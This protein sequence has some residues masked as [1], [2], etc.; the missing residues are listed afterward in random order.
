MG[1]R[2]I[3]GW[4]YEPGTSSP[5][6]TRLNPMFGAAASSNP[7]LR[8]ALS[9]AAARWG[10]S[11]VASVAARMDWHAPQETSC[12]SYAKL[13]PLARADVVRSAWSLM[14]LDVA[15]AVLCAVEA[16]DWSCSLLLERAGS[17]TLQLRIESKDAA[18][19]VLQ[20][21]PNEGLRALV[22]AALAVEQGIVCGDAGEPDRVDVVSSSGRWT[23]EVRT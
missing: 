11:R 17:S 12:I 15:D 8:E 3:T 4:A 16:E 22:V 9:K 18:D 5:W 23:V 2:P 21:S 20:D 10:G 13:G 14:E 7:L 6:A 1:S 19:L